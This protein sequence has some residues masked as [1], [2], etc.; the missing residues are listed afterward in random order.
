MCFPA[1][2][3]RGR[4]IAGMPS[5]LAVPKLRAGMHIGVGVAAGNLGEGHDQE[6]LSL[7]VRKPLLWRRPR[8]SLGVLLTRLGDMIVLATGILIAIKYFG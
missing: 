8:W 7:R 4:L 3:A 5:A 1:G 2:R 6:G